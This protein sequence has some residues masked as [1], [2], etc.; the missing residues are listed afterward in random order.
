MKLRV[1][2][3]DRSKELLIPDWVLTEGRDF[4]DKMDRDM[5]QGWQVGPEFIEN[6]N[7]LNRCQIAANKLL[8]A[9]ETQNEDLCNLM[10]GY[11]LARM[12][13]VEAVNI[14]T[15]G[16]PLLTEFTVSQTQDPGGHAL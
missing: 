15:Q 8:I 16:E 12:P 13:G 14:D 2:V 9:L 10:A 3:E 4:F 6:P 1:I 5:D 7:A 11:I